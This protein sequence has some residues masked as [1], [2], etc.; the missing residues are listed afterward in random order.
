LKEDVPVTD[1]QLL[2]AEALVDALRR[3]KLEVPLDT[4]KL[5][6]I[7]AMIRELDQAARSSPFVAADFGGPDE[8][9]MSRW[10]GDKLVAIER[11]LPWVDA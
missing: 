4:A 8:S 3:A 11:D 9:V 10:A 7:G 5:D 1:D 6:R 2:E